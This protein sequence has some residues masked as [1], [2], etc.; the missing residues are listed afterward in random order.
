MATSHGAATLA[1]QKFGR[2]MKFTKADAAIHSAVQLETLADAMALP[3]EPNLKDEPDAEENPFTPAGYTYLGQFIDHDL[4]FDTHS[5]FNKPNSFD[6]AIDMRTPAF[7]LDS[8]YGRGP[9]DQPYMYEKDG[10][11]LVLRSAFSNGGKDVLRAGLNGRAVIGDPRNDENAI[12]VQ[13]HVAFIRFHN[14]LVDQIHQDMPDLDWS[15]VFKAARRWTTHHYQRIII[16]DFLPRVVDTGLSSIQPIY[17]GLKSGTMPT[18]TLYDIAQG[19]YMPLEFAVAAYRFGHSMVRPDYRLNGSVHKRIFEPDGTGLTGFKP[20]DPSFVIDWSLFFSAEIGPGTKGELGAWNV[21]D[22]TRLQFAY[23]IDPMLVNPLFHL[24]QAVVKTMPSLA[25]RNLKRGLGFGLP[26]GETVASRIG[27]AVLTANELKV[28]LGNDEEEP[29]VWTRIV[30]IP[31]LDGLAGN[32]PLWFYILAE[33]EKGVVDKDEGGKGE[34]SRLGE[35]GG[36]IVVETF[37]GLMFADPTS[38]VNQCLPFRSIYNQATFSMAELFAAI[39]SP[40][41]KSTVKSK[42]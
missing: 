24:P 15:E 31:G 18:F 32:T 4:T 1:G 13:L 26:S 37:A 33:A 17:R 14:H 20:L 2:L 38:V 30:D 7:D 39:G 23:R 11:H 12:V 25:E 35:T 29:V 6:E 10:A 5:N 3:F 34:G 21:A 8:V 19:S 42:A 36:A 41:R 40:L 9:D 22:P 28:R 27:A 16:D